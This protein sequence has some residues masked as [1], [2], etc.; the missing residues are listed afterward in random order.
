LMV[1]VGG[2]AQAA[3]LPMIGVATLYFR[4]RQLHVRLRPSRL[5]DAM[6]WVAVLAIVAVALYAI[7]GQCVDF[8]RTLMGS[9]SP[10]PSK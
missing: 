1:K 7:P 5:S 6:L 9:H 2:I 10:S 8:V 4:Y 3:T